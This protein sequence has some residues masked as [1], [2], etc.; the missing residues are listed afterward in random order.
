MAGAVAGHRWRG[1]ARTIATASQANLS[2][3]RP[4]QGRRLD[5]NALDAA[6]VGARDVVGHPVLAEDAAR[7]LDD[8]VVGLE[9]AAGEVAAV[10]LQS[11]QAARARRQ[12]LEIA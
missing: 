10:A 12:D 7:H 11:L 3:G 6:F 1:N 5:E 9:E 4:G 2:R 8:D